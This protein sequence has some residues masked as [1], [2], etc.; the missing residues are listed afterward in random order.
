[1]LVTARVPANVR[2][3]V[4]GLYHLPRPTIVNALDHRETLAGPLFQACKTFRHVIGL[5]SLVILTADDE[6]FVIELI[7]G[8]VLCLLQADVVVGIECIPV[9]P[10]GN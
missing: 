7:A 8:A 4:H 3:V 10:A 5:T 9:Q 6:D 1:V 2:H